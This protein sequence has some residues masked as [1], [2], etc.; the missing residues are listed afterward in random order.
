LW[1]SDAEAWEEAAVGVSDP[2][3]AVRLSLV[4]VRCLVFVHWC[5]L[6]SSHFLGIKPVSAVCLSYLLHVRER[7]WVVLRLGYHN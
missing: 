4:S 2:Y 6:I 3:G 5:P 1:K 7:T